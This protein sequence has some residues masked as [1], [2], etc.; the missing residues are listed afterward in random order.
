MLAWRTGID[1]AALPIF[2]IQLGKLVKCA[3]NVVIVAKANLIGLTL[4]VQQ[5]DQKRPADLVDW[6]RT[7]FRR[8]GLMFRS[9]AVATD[10]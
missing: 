1:D 9:V 10:L 6:Q 7:K 4:A 2:D 8:S 3:L 5:F